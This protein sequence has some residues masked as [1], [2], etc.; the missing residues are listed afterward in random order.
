MQEQRS[1]V[2]PAVGEVPDVGDSVGERRSARDQFGPERQ[3][4][5]R[6]EPLEHA[7]EGGSEVGQWIVISG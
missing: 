1:T 7:G 3:P 6:A 4:V 5:V 2:R